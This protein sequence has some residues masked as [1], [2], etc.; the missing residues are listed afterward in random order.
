M[1]GLGSSEVI[2]VGI[3]L[4]FLFGNKRVKEFAKKLGKSEA[5]M[6]KIQDEYQKALSNSKSGEK[7]DKTD[8]AV[9]IKTKQNSE[10]SDEKPPATQEPQNPLTKA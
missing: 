9:A 7:S 4:L 1:G 10:E 8:E 3:V 2:V 6:Q 5:E